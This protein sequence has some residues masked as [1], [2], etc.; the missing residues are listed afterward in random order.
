M[1]LHELIGRLLREAG[2]MLSTRELADLVNDDGS[3]VKRDKTR[4]T[5]FQIHGRT[6]NYSSIF[7]RDG[8]LVGLRDWERAANQL[9]IDVPVQSESIPRLETVEDHVDV[10]MITYLE[11]TGFELLGTIGELLRFGLPTDRILQQCGVYAVTL[12]AGF[13][14]RFLTPEEALEKGN[15]I[16][17][18]QEDYLREKWVR[19]VD[20]VYYGIAG[21]KSCRTLAERLDDLLRHSSGKTSTRGPH[22][23]G[24]ILWQLSGSDDLSIWAI[25]TDGPPAPKTLETAL[26]RTFKKVKRKLP[27]ANRQ[28]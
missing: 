9:K 5:D 2:R 18:R 15:V 13:T 25:S 19:D 20:V 26:L 11:E 7:V 10:C 1:T 4:V 6:R 17:P 24:E 22:S 12:P 8:S 27:F 14:P 3:Y 23:G 16:R 28:L 21:L